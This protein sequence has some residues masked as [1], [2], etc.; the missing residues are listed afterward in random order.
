MKKKIGEL[1]IIME[2]P[3]SAC[4]PRQL[5]GLENST[6]ATRIVFLKLASYFAVERTTVAN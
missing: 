1:L 5:A 3:A 6:A 4:R 2:I